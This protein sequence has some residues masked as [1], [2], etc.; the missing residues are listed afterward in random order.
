[1]MAC[2]LHTSSYAPSRARSVARAY[3]RWLS[4]FTRNG[5]VPPSTRRAVRSTSSSVATASRRSSSVTRQGAHAGVAGLIWRWPSDQ[6]RRWHGPLRGAR[7]VTSGRRLQRYA[8]I[9]AA[10]AAEVVAQSC[11]IASR[12]PADSRQESRGFSTAREP[13]A[14]VPDAT[15][16]ER[17][18]AAASPPDAT[19]HDSRRVAAAHAIRL[20]EPPAERCALCR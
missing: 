5:C 18:A 20:S 17:S 7:P 15:T 19:T 12:G 6:F 1:M 10:A 11:P 14:P 3:R 2:R 13:A 16:R 4:T 9:V 8:V